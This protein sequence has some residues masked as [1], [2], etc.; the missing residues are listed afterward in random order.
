VNVDDRELLRLLR[1][2]GFA[3]DEITGLLTKVTETH[4]ALAALQA[5]L[6]GPL[7]ELSQLLE[8]SSQR[9][10]SDAG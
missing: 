1:E 10:T 3:V 2:V 9:K 7:L 8:Q 6:T 5:R 4:E